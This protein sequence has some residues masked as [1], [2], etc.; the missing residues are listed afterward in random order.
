MLQKK[1]EFE[2]LKLNILTTE[3][4]L[5]LRNFTCNSITSEGVNL[6]TSLSTKQDKLSAG[7]NITIVANNV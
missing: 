4:D 1:G 3:S 2:S 7:T 6:N 5:T